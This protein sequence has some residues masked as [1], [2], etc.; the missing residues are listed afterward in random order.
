MISRRYWLPTAA[1]VVA[2]TATTVFAAVMVKM[3]LDDLVLEA[4]VVV[5]ARVEGAKAFMDEE[6]GRIFT[7]HTLTVLDYLKGKGDRTLTL[8]TLGGELEE[9]GQLVPG[10]ARFTPGEVV[11]V[12]LKAT[13]DDFAVVGMS[14]GKFTVQKRKAG[15]H[16]VRDFRGAMFV[17]TKGKTTGD[18]L[19]F[20]TF[21]EMVRRLGE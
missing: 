2:L 16:L 17:G 5:H 7:R 10:E 8:L 12:C 11:V 1:L 18:E 3:T 19:P 6:K 21:R 14:Q 13:G 20:D 9:I 15:A 4:D